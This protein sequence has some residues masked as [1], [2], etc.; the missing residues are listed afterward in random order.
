MAHFHYTIMGGLVFT[1]FAAIYYWV[2]KMTGF[3][4]NERLGK[5]HFWA[6]FVA[7]NSTFRR[8]SRSASSGSRAA[9]S[10]T[11][12]TSSSSTTGCRSRRSCSALSMLVF[13]VNLVWSLLFARVPAEREPVG[14]R[15]IEW[16]LP[17]P[18]PVHE[19][20]PDPGVH[21]RPVRL[22]R[23]SRPGRAP[24]S[25]AGPGEL[26]MAEVEWV[27]EG[28]TYEIVESEPPEL[29]GAQPRVRGHICSR[30]RPPFFFLGFVFAYFYLRSLNSNRPV[31]AG[32]RRPVADAGNA[33]HR[34]V[35]SRSDRAR[36]LGNSPTTGPT[37]ARQWR[38]KGAVALALGLA[39]V[40]LQVVE[41]TH[42]RVRPGRR[43]L[44]ERLL[45]LDGVSRPLRGRLAVLARDDA[46]DV[47]PLPERP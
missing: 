44:C 45:R 12:R 26:T 3:E 23:R 28:P 22:R 35:G 25:R 43:R 31:A 33:R 32:A 7:F 21:E 36:A 13:L 20:R 2:P 5:I 19:L 38:V 40:V 10:P 4:L 14:S 37:A 17:S 24:D 18:V 9:S 11:R 30:A 46:G 47:D 1:F 16:Q 41:W 15:S 27:R 42:V 34:G 29:L 39:G 6:M 8:S